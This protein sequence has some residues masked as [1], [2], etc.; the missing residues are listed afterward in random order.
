MKKIVALALLA[1]AAIATP[2]MAQSA[3]GTIQV[4]GVVPGKCTALTP[5]TGTIT[6]NDISTA[7]GTVLSAFSN[8]AGGLSR[9]FTVVCT[10]AN[11]SISVS[12]DALNNASDA[13]T[14]GGYTG[15]VHY[16]S[17]LSAN[18]AGGGAATA[19]YTTADVLPAATT[20]PLADR[21]A[22][23]ANNVTVAVSNGTTTNSGDVLKAG[24][25]SS[26]ITVT[27]APL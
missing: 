9:S 11:A 13:S 1:T 12:S 24:N 26:T 8:N 17:T 21:L 19:V 22:V 4:T 14:G 5:I 27:V 7:T 16:T 2:A 20:T 6:L 23:G 25:Y 18:K 10:S 15:R 3:S